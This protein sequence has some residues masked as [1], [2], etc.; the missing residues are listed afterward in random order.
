MSFLNFEDK[1]F[2]VFGVANRKSVAYAVAKTL[3]QEGATVIYSVRSEQRKEQLGSKLLKI[4]TSISVILK[5]RTKS[6]PL[7]KTSKIKV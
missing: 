5:T 3:E 1:T 7:Q 6:I 2:L 4:V